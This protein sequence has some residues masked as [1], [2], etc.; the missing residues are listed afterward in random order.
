MRSSSC[1]KA[2]GKALTKAKR[3]QTRRRSVRRPSW[4]ELQQLCAVAVPVRSTRDWRGYQTFHFKALSRESPRQYPTAERVWLYSSRRARLQGQSRPHPF[5]PRPILTQC[6][7]KLFVANLLN[8]SS[9][10]IGTLRQSKPDAKISRTVVQRFCQALAGNFGQSQIEALEQRLLDAFKL[11]S[12][13]ENVM[14]YPCSVCR[15]ANELAA[16]RGRAAP[17]AKDYSYK[18]WYVGQIA[19]SS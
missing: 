16:L 6:L 4:P 9:K 19:M 7:I 8:D 18:C 1:R 12:Q 15:A 2:S 13:Y 14:R 11:L 10:T 3:V 17:K 5:T